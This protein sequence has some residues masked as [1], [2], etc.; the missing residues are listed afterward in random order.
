MI[1]RMLVFW[2]KHRWHIT[3]ASRI[4]LVLT[5]AILLSGCIKTPFIIQEKDKIY[6]LKSGAEVLVYYDNKPLKKIFPNDMFVVDKDILIGDAAQAI[7]NQLNKV[8]LESKVKRIAGIVGAILAVLAGVI[9]IFLKTKGIK[10]NI[11]GK[12]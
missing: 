2:E 6:T 9:A 4:T 1:I 3:L 12:N 10:F 11:T 8:A 7:D 5:L